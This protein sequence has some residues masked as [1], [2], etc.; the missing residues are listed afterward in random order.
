MLSKND[1]VNFSIE[2]NLFFQ[3]I[4][5][6]HLFFIEVNL[7]PVEANHIAQARTLKEDFE[8]LLS[9]TILLSNGDLPKY[10]IDSNELVTPYTLKAEE[11]TSKL[12]GANINTD[13]TKAE[14][15]FSSYATAYSCENL[16]D[17]IHDLNDK[18]YELL[19]KVIAFK[20]NILN[21]SSQCKIFIN[22]Y[23]HLLEHIIHEA[24]YYLEILKALKKEDLPDKSLC[25]D[26]DFWN[27][28]M[29]DHGKFIDGMLDPTEENLKKIAENFIEEYEDLVKDCIEATKRKILKDSLITT[30][31]FSNYK[32]TAVE[33]L[34]QCKIKSI[35]PPL[36]ADHVLREA[37]HYLRLLK[38]IS[39]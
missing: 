25:E 7:P 8:K 27:H 11:L 39:H 5:K 29:E 38:M 21:L 28:I 10:I 3:R 35:I 36:L 19:N 22:M 9:K 16:E 30:E 37:N 12:T 31:K 34:L 32:R 20:K 6:E 4:M 2:I 15:K 24:E 14:L 1:F 33:G 23:P 26:L 18:S 17:E 13:I